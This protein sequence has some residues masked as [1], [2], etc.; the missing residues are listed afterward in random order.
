MD[1]IRGMNFSI[2]QGLPWNFHGGMAFLIPN[3][4]ILISGKNQVNA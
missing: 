3:H 1:K 2:E 4:K